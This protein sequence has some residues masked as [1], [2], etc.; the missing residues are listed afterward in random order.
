MEF[1]ILVLV[2]LGCCLALW[3]HY[4]L[5]FDDRPQ[6]SRCN[7]ETAGVGAAGSDDL[8]SAPKCVKNR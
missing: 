2:V 1:L 7:R 3:I 8:N 5:A 6:C 4:S